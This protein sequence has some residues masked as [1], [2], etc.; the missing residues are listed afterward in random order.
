MRQKLGPYLASTRI[1]EFL[2][3]SMKQFSLGFAIIAVSM[4]MFSL[5]TRADTN[6]SLG[7]GFS[8]GSGGYP[9]YPVGGPG[10]GYGAGYGSFG[11]IGGVC[12]GMP[13]PII[14]PPVGVCGIPCVGGGGGGYFGPGRGIASP[15]P[16]MPAL[17]PI[18]PPAPI[19]PPHLA[20]PMPMPGFGGG[21]G[22]GPF[23]PGGPMIPGMN[24]GVNCVPCII[25]MNPQIIGPV[26]G[27]PPMPFPGY[28]NAGFQG[29]IGGAGPTIIRV[30]GINEWEKSDTA[31]IVW[32]AGIGM[33][34]QATNVY[35]AM[36]PRHAPTILP[37]WHGLGPRDSSL[38]PR[39]HTAP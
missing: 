31:D 8:I 28:G 22:G 19:L 21:F 38:I 6:W 32:A 2:G 25:G 29:A 35:P 7:V 20:M 15:F 34:M 12:T 9:R 26:P 37:G 39:P 1:R 14:A 33:G 3:G 11:A 18:P 17:P 16:A 24:T 4:S 5:E 13:A 27:G 36:M 10:F 30:G 23:P